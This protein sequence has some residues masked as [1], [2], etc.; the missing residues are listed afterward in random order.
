MS[1]DDDFLELEE[2]FHNQDR[3]ADRKERKIAQKRD[4]SKYKKSNLEKVEVASDELQAGEE[5]G[6]ILQVLPE[7][8]AIVELEGEELTCHFK[9]ALRKEKG[10]NRNILAVGD[11]VHVVVGEELIT[12]IRK[13]SS[14]LTRADSKNANKRH[15]LAANV[16]QVLITQSVTLPKLRPHL[17]DRYII[18]CENGNMTPIIILNKIDLLKRGSEERELFK[19]IEVL[20]SS[21]GYQVISVSAERGKNLRA[22]KKVMKGKVSV[23]SGQSG[24]GKTSLINAMTGFDFETR[25]I[26]LQNQK[27]THTTTRSILFP[28]DGGGY[29][30]DTPG[31]K[32]FGMEPIDP[33]TIRAYFTEITRVG[34][35]C[36][37]SSCTHVHEPACAVKAAVAEGKISSLRYQSYCN[38]I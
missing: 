5:L 3:K 1:Y 25:E 27:G 9:G 34:E 30:I 37:F 21:L 36:R 12:H 4:R 19:E 26:M 14:E 28:I 10:L 29:C 20:Y 23:F 6:R 8:A 35:G 15:V 16:D 24:V 32:S 38:L 18:A 17:L 31:I 33:A 2:E 13:R 7:N 11:L 22:L